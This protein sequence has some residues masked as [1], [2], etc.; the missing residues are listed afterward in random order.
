MCVQVR[1]A[2]VM[3]LEEG[4]CIAVARD[5]MPD[6]E[7]D[8]EIRRHRGQLLHARGRGDL[9]R[10]LDLVVRMPRQP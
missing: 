9:V 3:L 8:D 1:D 7:V 10:I 2:G 5:E 4:D 6:V